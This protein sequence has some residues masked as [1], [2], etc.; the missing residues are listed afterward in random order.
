MYV[1]GELVLV[2]EMVTSLGMFLVIGENSK[3]CVFLFV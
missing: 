2:L 1:M 3:V